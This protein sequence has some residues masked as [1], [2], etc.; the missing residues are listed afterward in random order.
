V[1]SGC[2]THNGNELRTKEGSGRTTAVHGCRPKSGDIGSDSECDRTRSDVSMPQ[3][4]IPTNQPDDLDN[5]NGNIS[6]RTDTGPGG[7]PRGAKQEVKS[8]SDGFLLVERPHG[9][10]NT[11]GGHYTYSIRDHFQDKDVGLK[12]GRKRF[13]A[14]AHLGTCDGSTSLETSLARFQNCAQYF[15]WNEKD[16]VFHLRAS[17]TGTAGQTLWTNTA[18]LSTTSLIDLLR[19]RFGNEN[20]AE[21]FRA[22]L[23]SRKRRSGESLQ[24]LCQ[25]VCRLMSLANHRPHSGLADIVGRDAFLDA[26]DDH[27]LRVRILEKEP[28]NID[29]ALNI[30]SRLGAYNRSGQNGQTEKEASD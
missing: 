12:Y 4:G 8:D 18:Q 20:Q 28:K 9:Q 1:E 29:E 27:S 2:P 26:L 23:R 5:I 22:E 13:L 19:T 7:S 21:R 3:N 16:K 30:A 17:L 11:E 24:I 14:E 10:T 15:E 25:D 6:T